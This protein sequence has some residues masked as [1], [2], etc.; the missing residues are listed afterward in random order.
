MVIVPGEEV[1]SGHLS[2]Q[3]AQVCRPI[4]NLNL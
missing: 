4:A 3:F 1:L 2:P